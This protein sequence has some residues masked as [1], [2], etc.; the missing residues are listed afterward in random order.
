[1]RDVYRRLILKIA[2]HAPMSASY[3]KW[4][5][6]P[7]TVIG[8]ASARMD[9][10]IVS[11]PKI[12]PATVFGNMS[13]YPTAEKVVNMYQTVLGIESKGLCR[14]MCGDNT[15]RT[16]HDDHR[17]DSTVRYSAVR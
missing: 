3:A 4:K 8:R 17:Q 11:M 5:F 16:T 14:N 6:V 13:P 9:R 2:H 1:M 15:T 7:I 10:N 12:L